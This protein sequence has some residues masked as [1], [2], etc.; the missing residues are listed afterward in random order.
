[1]AVERWGSYLSNP[2]GT[3]NEQTVFVATI[4]DH[5]LSFATP[6]YWRVKV[7]EVNPNNGQ[8]GA[9]SPWTYYTPSGG[10]TT[11]PGTQYTTVLH[12]GPWANF[13]TNPS[14]PIVGTSTSFTNASICY[15]ATSQV[16]CQ[17]YAWTF[18]DG[19]SSTL[20]NPS[21]TYAAQGS[22]LVNLKTYDELGFCE[23]NR[24]LNAGSTNNSKFKEVSPF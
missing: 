24:S 12:S 15:N 1:V 21:H 23:L 4:E 22:Y 13:S 7:W 2:P 3:I 11:A 9:K 20:Q 14:P 16:P 17:S 5:S 10:T 6:Y 18:G 8:L 19:G